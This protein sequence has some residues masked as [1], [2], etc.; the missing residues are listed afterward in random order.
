MGGGGVVFEGVMMHG[1]FVLNEQK[2]LHCH[3]SED[4]DLL[5]IDAEENGKKRD[6]EKS[7][8]NQLIPTLKRGEKKKKTAKKKKKCVKKKVNDND[9][10][11]K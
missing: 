11:E 7:T 4:D 9:E 8:L 5:W 2:L 6:L 10:S 1:D 3:T